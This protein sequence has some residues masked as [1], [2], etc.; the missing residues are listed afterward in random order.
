[1]EGKE[2]HRKQA[3]ALLAHLPKRM[4]DEEAAPTTWPADLDATASMSD[5]A[6]AAELGARGPAAASLAQWMEAQLQ[7]EAEATTQ[8]PSVAPRQTPPLRRVEGSGEAAPPRR[9]GRPPVRLA[10]LVVAVDLA[11]DPDAYGSV[12]QFSSH[13]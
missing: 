2:E 5:E 10:R 12:W 13:G 11:L 9:E 3:R 6:V 7:Q 1:M 8:P 4:E